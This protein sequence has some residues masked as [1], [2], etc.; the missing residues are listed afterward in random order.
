MELDL[1]L[2]GGTVLDGTGSPGRAADV[3]VRDGRI[4]V[5]GA[6]G[7]LPDADPEPTPA[8]VEADRR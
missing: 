8:E 4:V 7:S 1:R 6:P 2:I 3:G 5:V